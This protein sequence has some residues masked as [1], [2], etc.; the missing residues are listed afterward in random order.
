M[1]FS[2]KSRA[3]TCF[4]GFSCAG[5][6]DTQSSVRPLRQVAHDP[7]VAQQGFLEL[8]QGH[9][10]V[11]SVQVTLLRVGVYERQAQLTGH[12]LQAFLSQSSIGNI[13]IG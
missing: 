7:V 12:P 6:I 8:S 13:E 11:V 9:R 5:R 2:D 4:R 1:W 10:Y 3:Y